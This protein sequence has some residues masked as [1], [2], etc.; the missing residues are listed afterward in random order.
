[1][2]SPLLPILGSF[3]LCAYFFFVFRCFC[4]ER[5]LRCPHFVQIP[6]YPTED[7]KTDSERTKTNQWPHTHTMNSPLNT[8]FDDLANRTAMDISLVNDNARIHHTPRREGP[9]TSSRLCRWDS[10]G[11]N[12]SIKE[13]TPIAPIRAKR[14]SSDTAI[15]SSKGDLKKEMPLT[16]R[17]RQGSTALPYLLLVDLPYWAPPPKKPADEDF[18]SQR[19]LDDITFACDEDSFQKEKLEKQSYR[20]NMNSSWIIIIWKPNLASAAKTTSLLTK[21]ERKQFLEHLYRYLLQ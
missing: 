19:A 7:N 20:T 5:L 13:M 11:S 10:M 3:S 17:Y 6:W 14:S 9:M 18:D 16:M 12:D 21:I 15:P 2:N 1:M 8:Y 4:Y